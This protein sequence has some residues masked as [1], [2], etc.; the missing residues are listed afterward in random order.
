MRVRLGIAVGLALAACS[1]E[2]PAPSGPGG[3][4]P[5]PDDDAGDVMK[6]FLAHPKK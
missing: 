2:P 4:T 6:F 5:P 1:T 3:S